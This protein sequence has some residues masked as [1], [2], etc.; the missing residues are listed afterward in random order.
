[1]LGIC[2][3][4][5]CQDEPDI[6]ALTKLANITS[7]STSPESQTAPNALPIPPDKQMVH[8]GRRLTLPDLSGCIEWVHKP[9]ESTARLYFLDSDLHPI[10]NVAAAVMWLTE[11]TGPQEVAMTACTPAEPGCRQ[12]NSPG[13]SEAVPHGLVRFEVGRERYRIALPARQME[14][15]NTSRPTPAD[16]AIQP[17]EQVK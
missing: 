7:P 8:G 14:R 11:P 13:L 1:M 17:P 2:S 5:G 16:L 12:A 4:V 6:Q 9:G 3:F 10:D 15:A